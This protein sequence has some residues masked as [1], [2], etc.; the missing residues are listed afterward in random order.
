MSSGR[1]FGA[2]GLLLALV[3]GCTHQPQKTAPATSAQAPS[4]PPAQMAALASPFPPPLPVVWERPILK[5]D[6][7][8]PPEPK[9]EAVVVPPRRPPRR[10]PRAA[11]QENAQ[12]ETKTPP[13]PAPSDTPS[14]NTQVAANAQPPEMS[15]IGQLSTANDNT[16]TAD[17]NAIARQI[18]ETENGLNGIKRP[19]S[20][21][22]QKTITQIRTYITRARE[23]L[24]NDD[25]D[26]AR[27]TS[28][29]AHVLLLELTKQ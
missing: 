17:R 3:T 8:T 23:A 9:T 27:T 4:L 29:K 13:T 22:E 12:P 7:T 18:D 16:N 1:K 26:G 24:K 11:A 20:A 28:T 15:P 19:L 10:H 5:L 6:A 2:L 21:D 25:L 14:Q